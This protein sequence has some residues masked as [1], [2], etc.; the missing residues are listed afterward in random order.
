MKTAI[1]KIWFIVVLMAIC[2]AD[3]YA[4]EQK[5]KSDHN[6]IMGKSK[7]LQKQF[8]LNDIFSL[9]VEKTT[10][11]KIGLQQIID[12]MKKL[13]MPSSDDAKAENNEAVTP[14][15]QSLKTQS[16]SE[17][18]PPANMVPDKPQPKE[19]GPDLIQILNKLLEN[20]EKIVDPLSAAQALFLNDKMTNAAK[21]YQI[22]LQRTDSIDKTDNAYDRQWI[23]FQ[24]GNCLRKADPDRA[25]DYYRQLIEEYPNSGWTTA[26]RTCQQ[27]ITW[28]KQNPPTVVLE[29][30]TSD[31]NSI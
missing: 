14:D 18:T 28:Y 15:A 26:A 19:A 9:Q 29:K 11:N 23:L 31:P 3:S 16:S 4:A 17:N 5:S 12:E 8:V 10:V 1:S 22:A 21:F 20:P 13:K 2:S 30:I 24:M 7:T 6:E 27:V 25:H